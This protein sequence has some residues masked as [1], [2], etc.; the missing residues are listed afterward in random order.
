MILYMVSFA[1]YYKGDL[2]MN[3]CER[4]KMVKAM[5]Y[6]ARQVNDETV[7]DMWLWAGVADGDIEYGDLD[8][9]PESVEE[10]S[11]Y[12]EDKNFGELMSVFST[13]MFRAR[14][15]GGLYCDGVTSHE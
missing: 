7:F 2:N 4:L 10:L 3:K 5:E 6:I 11:Y 15:S 1:Q 9:S 14:Y 13:L 8:D 12:L